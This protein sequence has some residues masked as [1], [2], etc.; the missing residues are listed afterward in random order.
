MDIVTGSSTAL[1]TP[2]KDGKL[3]E[4]TFADLI[5]RQINNGIDAV[6][7]VGTTGESATLTSD[8]DRRCMEIAVEVCK[9]TRTK[10][11]AGAGSN[12]TAEAINTAKV[13]LEVGVDAFFSVSPYYNKPS[14]E[15]LYQ[16]YKAI[17]DAVPEL[18]M[19]L[20]NVPGRT[21]VDIVAD[22]V[23]RLF[24]DCKN[25]YGI[26]EATGS[27]ER[28]VELLSRIPELKVF[29]GDDAIDFPIL[30]NGGAGITS[31]T[32]NLM[33]D[34]K[35]ELVRLALMGDFAGAKA[36]NDKLYPLNKVMFCESNPIPVKAAMYIAG[37]IPTLEYRLPLTPPSVENMK[38]IEQVMKNYEI[39][40]L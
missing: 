32:S 24:R 37:L 4:Q 19:M 31:V 9:G 34:L 30:A 7:P 20:Y 38:K 26:K 8:E 27:L 40:G 39:K 11:L 23:E 21:G 18:P 25:I 2:F 6:C 12:S 35:S 14:Q 36:I 15:G 22:T 3:D 10:V 28:T 13:A 29:S 17:A 1:I 5:K 33:P 16:H